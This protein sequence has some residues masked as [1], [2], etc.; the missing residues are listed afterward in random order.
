M[1]AELKALPAIEV[2]GEPVKPPVSKPDELLG[3][4]KE[5]TMKYFD[6]LMALFSGNKSAGGLGALIMTLLAGVAG[7]GTVAGVPVGDITKLDPQAIAMTIVAGLGLV[8]QNKKT[9]EPKPVDGAGEGKNPDVN[10]LMPKGGGVSA[11]DGKVA[12]AIGKFLQGN[13][14]EEDAMA[15]GETMAIMVDSDVDQPN[16]IFVNA[17]KFAEMCYKGGLTVT[18]PK[19]K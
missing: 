7:D 11:D 1:F 15:K 9:P 16:D 3:Q 17:L 13:L 19:T 2:T 18:A 12:D 14:V 8:A 10:D 6:D 5:L 4:I